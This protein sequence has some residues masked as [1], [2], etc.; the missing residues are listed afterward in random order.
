MEWTAPGTQSALT[1]TK[2]HLFYACKGRQ[3]QQV[4][5]ELKL[6]RSDWDMYHASSYFLSPKGCSL[7]IFVQNLH[8]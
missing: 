4:L 6:L 7:I 8:V 5:R 1:E 3:R 2:D